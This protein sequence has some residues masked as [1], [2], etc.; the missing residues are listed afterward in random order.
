MKYK[1]YISML[2]LCLIIMIVGAVQINS[3]QLKNKNI[4]NNKEEYKTI[5]SLQ[6]NALYNLDLIEDNDDVEVYLLAETEDKYY[7]EEESYLGKKGD[8]I[9]EGNF[10]FYLA[11]ATNEQRAFKQQVKL[12]D[13]MVFNLTKK[14]IST[15]TL[16]ERPISA[17]IQKY[18]K[19]KTVA[20]LF[21]V[22]DN[23]L[24][25]L[26]ESGLD[27]Y[28]RKIK[29]IQQNY[30]QTMNKI[31]EN[32][33]EVSTWKLDNNQKKLVDLDRT[34]VSNQEIVN[35]W[36]DE[37][38]YYYPFKNLDVSSSIL[39]TAKQGMLIGSQYPI[40]TNIKEIEKVN[41]KYVSTEQKNGISQIIY[42]EV[43]YYYDNKTE[44]VT[45]ISIPGIRFK[46]NLQTIQKELGEPK[47]LV[48]DKENNGFIATYTAGNYSLIIKLNSTQD[49]EEML[50]QK[51]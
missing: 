16:K 41:K 23:Q 21:T 28:E 45:S 25:S 36:L 26:T 47:E 42:P 50:L 15:Y 10:T 5:D 20:Y 35:T 8:P 14:N 27:V 1:K 7:L 13:R 44:Q 39:S 49:M 9:I 40:G 24:V 12:P 17:I 46:E 32:E 51:K 19:D 37:E 6:E 38:D 30:L 18:S 3:Y 48:A 31:A 11:T 43:T 34:T 4:N 2:V 22:K 33:F 29:N